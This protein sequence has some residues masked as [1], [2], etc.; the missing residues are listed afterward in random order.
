MV[1]F[2]LFLHLSIILLMVVLAPILSVNATES[3][4]LLFPKSMF[5]ES[6]TYKAGFTAGFLDQPFLGHHEKDYIFGYLNGTTT[7]VYNYND[8]GGGHDLDFYIGFHNGAA[9]A[10]DQY[11]KGGN[12]AY[13]GCLSGHGESYCDGFKKGYEGDANN[14]G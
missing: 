2:N 12:F 8:T 4:K 7:Y 6:D 10:D 1:F 14:L 9:I 5:P 11:H 13:P 3:N